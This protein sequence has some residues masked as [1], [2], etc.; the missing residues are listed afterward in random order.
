M[1]NFSSSDGK[2]DWF[3]VFKRMNSNHS[4]Y[5]LYT[6]WNELNNLQTTA[7]TINYRSKSRWTIEEVKL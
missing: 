3:L 5:E 2:I 4:P 6:K 1:N 7:T